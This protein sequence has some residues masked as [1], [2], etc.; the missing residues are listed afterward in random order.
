[1]A[2]LL[3]RVR[4]G[5]R[6]PLVD[7]RL[8]GGVV[9]AISPDE[10]TGGA[11]VIDGRGGTLL[12]GLVDA[13]V[14]AAQWA[15]TRRRIPLDA[16]TSAQ[17]AVD[18]VAGA[19]RAESGE[20]VMGSDFRDGLWPDKPHKDLLERA[21]PGQPVALFSNDLHTLWLSPAALQLIGHDHPTG[22]LVEDDCYRATAALPAAPAPMLDRWVLEAADAAAARG[23]T[24]IRDFEYTGTIADW[25]RRLATG[26]SSVRE[27]CVVARHLLD[28][29]TACG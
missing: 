4:A 17:Q 29:P 5:L 21:L 15:S 10:P 28:A 25:T 23:V 26:T 6:G 14:H 16:A 20:I 24:G 7:V 18:L 19:A 13:H 2:V 27:G 1:M 3:R 8:A 12:P 11:L 9:A 22:V